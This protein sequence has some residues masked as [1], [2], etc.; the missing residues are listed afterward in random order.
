MSQII[1]IANISRN[2]FRIFP[3]I[4]SK[5]ILVLRLT[6]TNN[7]QLSIVVYNTL[8][9]IINQVKSLLV[10]ETR[11]KTYHILFLVNLQSKFFLNLK[12]VN[13]FKLA[14][15]A[16]IIIF[17]QLGISSWIIDCIVDTIY[18]ALHIKMS[19]L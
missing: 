14:E 11:N 17:V 19:G 4:M 10:S 12:L 9:T 7:N 3:C 18:Y 1:C 6:G 16:G 5:H 13:L 15:I 2:L 8:N